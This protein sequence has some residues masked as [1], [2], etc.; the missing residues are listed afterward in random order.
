[1]KLFTIIVIRMTIFHLLSFA[2]FVF[3]YHFLIIRSQGDD[4]KF[5]VAGGTAQAISLDLFCF[6]GHFG[7][8]RL[9]SICVHFAPL[10]I[11]ARLRCVWLQMINELADLRFCKF[12]VSQCDFV[13]F[14]VF[15]LVCFQVGLLFISALNIWRLGG[16]KWLS[17][18]FC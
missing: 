17:L 16:P 2:M 11:I 10:L 18:G 4:A 7:D 15:F 1:M 8:S 14:G 6:L 9:H 12:H 13:H 5:A 3:A